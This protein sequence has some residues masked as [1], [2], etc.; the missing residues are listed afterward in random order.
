M[1][2]LICDY[3]VD[4]QIYSNDKV[5]FVMEED[6]NYFHKVIEVFRIPS[7]NFEPLT[8]E[9]LLDSC[10]DYDYSGELEDCSAYCFWKLDLEV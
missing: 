1:F 6:G 2:N 3:G 8:T 10:D 7:P 4:F 5:M 9:Q